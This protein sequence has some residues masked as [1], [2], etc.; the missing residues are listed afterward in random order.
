MDETG[1]YM[2]LERRMRVAV[3]HVAGALLPPLGILG[4]LATRDGC[5]VESLGLVLLCLGLLCL[6]HLALRLRAKKA[7]RVRQLRIELC[8]TVPTVPGTRHPC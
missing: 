3:K 5:L 7:T 4:R 8:A 1:K 6:A 2:L